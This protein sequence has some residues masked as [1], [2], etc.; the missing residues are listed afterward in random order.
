MRGA[1]NEGVRGSRSPGLV[2]WSAIAHVTRALLLEPLLI[3]F[4][5]TPLP[6]ARISAHATPPELTSLHLTSPHPITSNLIRPH[7]APPCAHLVAG[8][9]PHVIVL[10]I[11]KQYTVRGGDIVHMQ[12]DC[13]QRFEHRLLK[14]DKTATAWLQLGG[15]EVARERRRARARWR[16]AGKT[17]RAAGCVAFKKSLAGSGARGMTPAAASDKDRG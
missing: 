10:H 12:G 17:W 11:H 16:C 15:G 13:Q 2:V 6:H 5:L 4:P 7:A 8:D 9:P 3:C 14:D 1:A